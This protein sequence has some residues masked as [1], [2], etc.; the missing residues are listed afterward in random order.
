M[1]E[2]GDYS[3]SGC[4]IDETYDSAPQVRS[5]GGSDPM[6]ASGAGA[7]PLP[8]RVDLRKYCSS[9]EDQGSTASCVGNAV[10][11]A[12]ELLQRKDNHSSQNLSRLFVYYNSRLFHSP[13]PQ[14]AGTFVHFAMASLI[15]HG[16]C[17]ERLWPFSMT[18]LNDRPTQA[19]YENAAN[20]RGVEFAQLQRGTPLTHVLAQ[21]I[22]VVISVQVAREA[23]HAAHK[24]GVMDAPEGFGVGGSQPG[25][26]MLAVGYDLERQTYLVRNS[27][28]ERFANQGYFEMPMALYEASRRPGM[29]WAIG[30]LNHAPTLELLGR[31]VKDSVA[32]M[33]SAAVNPMAQEVAQMRAGLSKEFE[34]RLGA[35]KQ[36][37][38]SRLR[39]S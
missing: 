10:V 39:G 14:D 20:Y 6:S 21:E 36:G 28:G 31:T 3:L 11:G 9:V 35:A 24:T 16:V 12:L 19:C 38:R 18:V 4:L 2:F 33:V 15:A 5:V 29:Q 1:D 34:S 17:E 25:H 32:G 37:F 23:Y 27:W 8:P 26:A 22:P 13:Q 7:A 30:A